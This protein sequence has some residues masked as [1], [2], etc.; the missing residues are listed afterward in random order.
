M[1]RPTEVSVQHVIQFCVMHSVLVLAALSTVAHPL[2]VW[3]RS[4]TGVSAWTP[5]SSEA[6]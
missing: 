4:E 5:A 6:Y 3:G 1:S 2:R